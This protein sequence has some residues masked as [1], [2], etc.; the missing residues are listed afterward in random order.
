MSSNRPVKNQLHAISVRSKKDWDEYLL[1][2][3]GLLASAHSSS[4][5]IEEIVETLANLGSLDSGKGQVP[6]AIGGFAPLVVALPM[7]T[8][9]ASP[10]VQEGATIAPTIRGFDPLIL[11]KP[12]LGISGVSGSKAL[13]AILPSLMVINP[14]MFSIEPNL[15]TYEGVIIRMPK[16]FPYKD[17]HRVPRNTMCPCLISTRTGKEE[18]CS[19]VSSGLSRLT[20]SGRYYTPEELEKRRKEVGKGT[21]KPI[22]NRVT[23]EEAEEFLKVIKNLEYSVI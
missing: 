19:N 21:T 14:K 12:A 17:S 13:E 18:V 2:C 20:M 10:L 8:R 3:L 15:Q 1:K 7:V 4:V 11:P 6:P 22:R 16:P 5:V 9:P 23:T